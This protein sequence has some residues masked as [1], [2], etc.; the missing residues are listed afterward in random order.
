MDMCVRVINIGTHN[1][2]KAF[3]EPFFS[4]PAGEDGDSTEDPYL[5]LKELRY[6]WGGGWESSFFVKPSIKKSTSGN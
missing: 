3:L 1:N 4:I 6:S 5:C 2:K